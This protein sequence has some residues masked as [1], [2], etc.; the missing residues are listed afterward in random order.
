MLMNFFKT[1]Y[2]KYRRIALYGMLMTILIFVLKWLQWNFLI[3]D[4]S[5]DIYIG[6]IAVF[7]TVL[8]TWI[9]LHLAKL[10]IQTVMVEKEVHVP[11]PKIFAP[12]E[13]ELQRLNLN[14]REYEVLQLMA[15]GCLSGP[16]Y[17]IAS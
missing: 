1:I 13:Y 2:L 3:V 9:S 15:K 6:M 11:V 16:A 17:R 12:N 7:F 10:R 5:L 14:Q 8:G 4:N